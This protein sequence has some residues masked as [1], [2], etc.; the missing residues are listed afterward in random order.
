MSTHRPAFDKTSGLGLVLKNITKSL[1][2]TAN[3]NVPVVINPAV[4]GGGEDQQKLFNSLRNGTLPQRAFAA[5]KMTESLTKY[6]ISSIT[7]VWYSA[8]D[9]CNKEVQPYIRRIGLKLL[10]ECINQCGDLV[11]DKLMFFTDILVLC[12]LSEKKV[13]PEYDLFLTALKS[14]TSDGKDIYDLCIFKEG[15]GLNTLLSDALICIWKS[16]KLSIDRDSEEELRNN[17]NFENLIETIKFARNCLKFNCSV[18]EEGTVSAILSK[19][20]T[21]G[22]ETNKDEI[23][24][25]IL[26]LINSVSAFG[27]IPFESFPR[28]IHFLS[29]LYGK[30][31]KF[32]EVVEDIIYLLQESGTYQ[33]IIYNLCQ[34]ILDNSVLRNRYNESFNDDILSR[35]GAI[36]LIEMFQ[37]T[38]TL[39]ERQITDSYF[40]LILKSIFTSISFNIPIINTA[41]LRSIDRILSKSSY[42]ENA[43]GEFQYQIEKALPFYPWHCESFSVYDIL[44]NLKL[45]SEQDTSYMKSICVSLQSLYVNHELH[46]PKD[47]LIYFFMANTEYLSNDNMIFILKYYS[48]EKMCSVLDPLWKEN[49]FKILNSFYYTPRDSEVKVKCLNVIKNGLETSRMLGDSRS[50]NY[51]VVVDILRKSSD[52]QNEEVADYLMHK[53]YLEIA[54][55]APIEVFRDLYNG[56]KSSAMK[57]ND[58]YEKS[59]PIVSLKS[60]GS[61][62]L[63]TRNNVD[64]SVKFLTKFSEALSTVFLVSTTQSDQKAYEAYEMLIELC[65]FALLNEITEVLIT[66]SKCLVRIRCTNEMYVFLTTVDDIIGL[67]T[68]FKRNTFDNDFKSVN[69]MWQFPETLSYLPEKYLDRPAKRLLVDT[70]DKSGDNFDP[71]LSIYTID[72]GKWLSIVLEVME[73]FVNWEIYSFIWAHFCGQLSNMALFQ[74][75]KIQISAIR[76]LTCHQLTL[77]LPSNLVFPS[78]ITKADLQVISARTLSALLAYHDFF[79][80]QEQDQLVTSLIFGLG[81]WE[82]TAIPCISIL[83]VCCCEIPL[84]IKKYL[85]VILTKLQTTITSVF[86]APLTLEFLLSLIYL[87]TLTSNFTKDEFK[88]VFGIAFKYIQYS[89]DARKRS[90][91]DVFANNKANEYGVDAVVEESV[92]TKN[93]EITPS[94]SQYLLTLSYSIISSWFLN[95]NMSDRKY[96][97]SFVVKNLILVSRSETDELDDQTI[98][99]LDLITR[100]T[101]SDMPLIITNPS[102]ETLISEDTHVSQFIIG[103]SILSIET[104]IFDGNFCIKIR[105]PT[106]VTALK[107]TVDSIK[108]TGSPLINSNYILLQ[109]FNNIDPK[110]SIKP[111]PLIEDSISIRALSILDRIPTVEFHKIG[112]MYIRKNQ[113]SEHEILGNRVGSRAYQSFLD[114]VG[115]LIRLKGCRNYY[116]GG[117]DIENDVDGE[118]ATFWNSKTMH[119][120]F[121]VTTM[122]GLSEADKNFDL[123]KRHIGNNYVNIY[124]DES[125][126]PF[127]FNVIKSQFNFLNIVISPSALSA[128]ALASE[129]YRRRRFFKVKVY[130][131]SGVPAVFASCHFKLISEE[132]LPFFIRNLAIS[133]DQFANAWHPSVATSH[134]SNWSHRAKQIKVLKEKTLGSHRLLQEENQKTIASSSTT[135]SFLLQLSPEIPTVSSG[136]T[137]RYE[138]LTSNDSDIYSLV[139]FNSYT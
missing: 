68:A 53:V 58:V 6:S 7:E 34:I 100:F 75:N 49:S 129:E 111:I 21:I 47:K 44:N 130:R 20:V 13:D 122:M 132:K 16:A 97:S 113:A 19:V 86:A 54:L 125:G 65:R 41:H 59:R 25:E 98:A 2:S 29:M 72:M 135:Q 83:T 131:R 22:S 71:S 84:S 38:S 107:G 67:A 28:V 3:K 46:S 74:K 66:I 60:N 57:S 17:K 133:A 123:K 55:E 139:E 35:L 1:R 33:I 56:I 61:F 4:I 102:I 124:F 12:Q 138:Y 69:F 76:K 23:N 119:V 32:R 82:K 77:N 48:D 92:S 108:G 62:A 31:D 94:M 110:N 101:Y 36:Q 24:F 52:E 11:G 26:D 115:R 5:E 109:L 120:V 112:I 134:L 103:S 89:N 42:N 37:V 91:K 136:G 70:D 114:R 27:S 118:Y 63:S 117:L 137:D 121:Q 88:R 105:R 8:R 45:S 96:L 99:F 18:L 93:I 81:S 39:Q 104:D 90:E 85:S 95:I 64:S 126:L 73:L 10:I 116:V 40:H 127:N 78:N 43:S 30:S 14:L 79:S 80:K 50:V 128:S 9:L 15:R 51:D 106:G 87:P